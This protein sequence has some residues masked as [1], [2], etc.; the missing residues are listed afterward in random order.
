MSQQVNSVPAVDFARQS[1]LFVL[2]FTGQSRPNFPSFRRI[3]S[4]FAA[5]ESEAKRV[6]A[7]LPDR[8]NHPAIVD[9][10]RCGAN[11]RVIV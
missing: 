1:P 4:S 9:G 10:P 11:G 6:L 8:A 7:A 3:F 5:A 2:T